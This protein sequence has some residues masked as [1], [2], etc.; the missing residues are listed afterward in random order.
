MAN[1]F[2]DFNGG[3]DANDGASYVNRKKTLSSA[4]AVAAAGDVIRVMGKP[5][6]SSG[7]ATWTKGSN[8]VTLSAAMTQLLYGDGAWSGV[9]ANVTQNNSFT[10]VKE[11]SNCIQFVCNSSFNTGKIAHL[12]VGGGTPINLGAYRQICFWIRSSVAVASGALNLQ[13]CS[14]TAGATVV[15]TVT[16][17]VALNANQWTAITIDSGGTLGTSIQSIQFNAVTTLT[18]TSIAVDNIFAAK[19]STANDCLTLNT[20]ISPDNATWYHVQSV[21]GTAVKLDGQMATAAGAAKGFQ[22]TTGSTTFYMLQPTQVSIGAASSNYAQVFSG[23]GSAGNPITISGGWDSTAMTTQSGWTAIDMRDWSGSGLNLSGTTGYVTVDKFAFNHCAFPLGVV[24]STAKGLGLTNSTCAGAGTSVLSGQP[25]HG[26]N[27]AGSNFLNCA[28]TNYVFDIPATAN[29][30]TDQ[31][32]WS[33]TNSKIWGASVGGVR[34]PAFVGSPAVTITGNDASGNTGIGFDIQSP[35][36][37]RNNTANNNGAPGVNFQSMADMVAYNVT[38]RGNTTGEVQVNN[39]NVEIYT[40]DTNTSGGSTVPQIFF[41]N[42][43]GG[44]AVVYNWTQYT[45]VSPAA[46]LASLGSPAAGQTANNS[47]ASQ[48]EGG[49]AANNSIYTDQGVITTTGVVGQPG[50]GIAWKLS[51]N[52]NAFAS[53]PLRLNIG[54]IACPANVPTTIKY[55]AK[56]SAAGPTAQ[57][58]VFGGRYAGVGSAGTDVVSAAI[59][60]TTFAQYSVTFTPTENCVVDVFAEVWGSSTQNLVVSGPVVISQ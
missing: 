12:Q 27:V 48:K 53:S 8:A 17:N 50:S 11:G 31:V 47:V 30:N 15:N 60:G 20:L 9:G 44:K 43:S 54:K 49:V 56:F 25:T 42:N 5:S 52:A 39:A 51:P 38:A 2:V 4:A 45:G 26:L 57:L 6:T 18:S 40:L 23:N 7:T 33:V 58:K 22:G 1:K 41:P 34:V 10:P 46:K 16:L 14:D 13:L 37:F 24:T 32:A 28:G 21:N 29:Y 36:A 19:I 35:C 55:Y 3:N 59:S